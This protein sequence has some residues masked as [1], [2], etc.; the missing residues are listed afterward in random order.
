MRNKGNIYPYC[1]KNR[2]KEP[3][4]SSGNWRCWNEWTFP[5]FS[6]SIQWNNTVISLFEILVFNTSAGRRCSLY[7][8][9][10]PSPHPRPDSSCCVEASG[11]PLCALVLPATG[12]T[13]THYFKFIWYSLKQKAG[14]HSLLCFIPVIPSQQLQGLLVNTLWKLLP[15]LIQ[16]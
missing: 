7:C 5:H 15:F 10:F 12:W 11:L 8:K 16:S 9:L 13:E 6:Y 14:S 3:C 4:I 1:R 2:Y